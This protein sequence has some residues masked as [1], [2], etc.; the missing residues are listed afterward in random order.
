MLRF[1]LMKPGDLIPHL[2]VALYA[3]VADSGNEQQEDEET[4]KKDV[5]HQGSRRSGSSSASSSRYF[6]GFRSSS[7]SPVV[8]ALDRHHP[9]GKSFEGVVVTDYK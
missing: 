9:I 1:G 7:M 3:P 4:E 5:S 6:L 8:R 2:I